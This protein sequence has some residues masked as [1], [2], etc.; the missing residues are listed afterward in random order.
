MTL[1]G[2][3]SHEVSASFYRMPRCNRITLQYDNLIFHCSGLSDEMTSNFLTLSLTF[4]STYCVQGG[5]GE[6]FELSAAGSLR[7]FYK[8]FISNISELHLQAKVK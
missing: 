4:I 8:I 6:K 2:R 1:F 5:S 3:V 7:D